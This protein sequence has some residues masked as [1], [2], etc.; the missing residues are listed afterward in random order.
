MGKASKSKPVRNEAL[1]NV[2]CGVMEL[3]RAE[4]VPVHVALDRLAPEGLRR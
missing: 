2:M 3:L 4:G 1:F